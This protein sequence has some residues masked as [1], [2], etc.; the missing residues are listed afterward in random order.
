MSDYIKDTKCNLKIAAANIAAANIAVKLAKDK[1]EAFEQVQQSHKSYWKQNEHNIAIHALNSAD[2][3]KSLMSYRARII[4]DHDPQ[5]IKLTAAID[6]AS[7]ITND[8]VKYFSA[9][10]KAEE[11]EFLLVSLITDLITLITNL[12]TLLNSAANIGAKR[13]K[14]DYGNMKLQTIRS[15]ELVE[16]IATF[17]LEP[18][19]VEL[20]PC[21]FA[22]DAFKSIEAIIDAARKEVAARKALDD[23]TKSAKFA[24]I[25]D[26][27]NAFDAKQFIAD[28]REREFLASVAYRKNLSATLSERAFLKYD[29]YRASV[30]VKHAIEICRVSATA[31]KLS[32]ELPTDFAGTWEMFTV[33]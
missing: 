28:L 17:V 13:N 18:K 15:T 9:H 25:P 8:A 14:F 29:V 33:K 26:V 23:Y 32:S 5:H 2:N 27:S 24:R 3:M 12:I 4:G 6:V 10:Y 20:A 7:L 11:K 30:D 21:I 31:V 1:L 22:S 16:S 19:N